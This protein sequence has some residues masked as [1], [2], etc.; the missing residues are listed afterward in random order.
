MKVT[1]VWDPLLEE[2]LC[3]HKNEEGRCPK[4]I[5]VEEQRNKERCYQVCRE[6]FEVL[7]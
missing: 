7:E 2:V 4:C 1:V 6:E 3:V 5:A